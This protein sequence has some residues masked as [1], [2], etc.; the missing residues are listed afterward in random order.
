LSSLIVNA[1]ETGIKMFSKK[2]AKQ[3]IGNS[4]IIKLVGLHV[5]NSDEIKSKGIGGACIYSFPEAIEYI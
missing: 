1:L 3:S 2:N 4:L 5:K